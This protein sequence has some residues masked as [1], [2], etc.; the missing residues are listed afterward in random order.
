M[1][2]MEII[3]FCQKS[4]TINSYIT[5]IRQEAALLGYGEPQIFEVFK[6][7][8]PLKSVPFPIEDLRSSRNG[9][10]NPHK[11]KSR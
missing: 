1:S 6:N 9:K 2:C 8:L 10:D 3:S 11:R 4:E 5:C 7:T